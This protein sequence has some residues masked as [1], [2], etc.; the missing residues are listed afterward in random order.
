MLPRLRPCRGT[1]Y[2]LFG[3]RPY[4]SKC[5]GRGVYGRC[6]LLVV[7]AAR[8]DVTA[9]GFARLPLAHFHVPIAARGA[10]GLVFEL[11]RL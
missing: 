4:D 8:P 11:G 9:T 7:T 10:S 1:I 6:W 3:E 2:S 5:T